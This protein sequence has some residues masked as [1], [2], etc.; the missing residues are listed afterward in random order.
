MYH[1]D[2]TIHI[3]R[4]DFEANTVNNVPPLININW[5]ITQLIMIQ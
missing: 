1:T 4:S 3:E 5:N 2:K